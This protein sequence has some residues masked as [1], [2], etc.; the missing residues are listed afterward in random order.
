MNTIPK[1]ER[2]THIEFHKALKSLIESVKREH[3]RRA[4]VDAEIAEERR[5]L[6]MIGNALGYSEGGGWMDGWMDIEVYS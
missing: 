6:V 5:L 4:T 3:L 2:A 1:D